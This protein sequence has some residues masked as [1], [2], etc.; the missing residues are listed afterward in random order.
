[1]T[2]EN[3]PKIS[4][5]FAD[6][7][8]IPELKRLMELGLF[9][10]ITTNPSIIAK[11]AKG[12]D[13]R[14][15]ILQIANLFPELPVSA[16]LLQGELPDLV[17]AAVD[18]AGIAP[19]VV[20]KIPAFCDLRGA[21]GIEDGKALQL[22]AALK[23]KEIKKNITALMSAEQAICYMMAGDRVGE[24]VQFVSL[25]FN[26]IKDGQGDPRQEVQNTREFIEKHGLSTEIIV[27]SIRSKEDV[28][29]AQMSGAHIVTIPPAVFWS[30][31]VAHPQSK[32]F[33][34]EAQQNYKQAF[35]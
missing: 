6:T 1:M 33:I 9:T 28:R 14:G 12:E 30:K 24:Q 21:M 34:D 15:Y 32:K 4:K 16:Q 20:V 23:G 10:G 27:G 2:V 19:N 29:E 26:R 3:R 18:I 35:K 5:Y 25:F 11:E 31:I 8:L 7:A 13:P 17:K 22:I